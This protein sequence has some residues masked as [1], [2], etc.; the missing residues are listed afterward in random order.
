MISGR[1]D[2]RVLRRKL[3]A[4]RAAGPEAKAAALTAGVSSMMTEICAP[5]P[6]GVPRD[7]NRLVRGWA[8]ANNTAGLR[9][10]V[11]PPL[12]VSKRREQAQDRLVDQVA[13]WKRIVARYH[14]QGRDDRWAR[15]AELKLERSR[16]ALERFLGDRYA[17]VIGLFSSL[18]DTGGRSLAVQVRT[19]LNKQG[20]VHGGRGLLTV[21]GGE[22]VFVMH[23]REPHASFPKNR[24]PVAEALRRAKQSALRRKG[25]KKAMAR[26][27]TAAVPGTMKA[28]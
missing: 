6:I 1:V 16:D 9:P 28:A 21:A 14:R 24:A 7:T 3:A 26:R 10:I 17:L 12:A 4:I 27:L 19:Q 15:N 5:P 13:F 11:L 8:M 18:T 25:M 20:E 22:P 2:D 23:N